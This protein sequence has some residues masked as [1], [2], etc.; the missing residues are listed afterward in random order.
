LKKA[1]SGAYFPAVS[2]TARDPAHH[3]ARRP[4]AFEGE[5]VISV[6]VDDLPGDLTLAAHGI[7]SDDDRLRRLRW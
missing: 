3:N 2:A 6:L 5:D 4:R 1:L 7:E